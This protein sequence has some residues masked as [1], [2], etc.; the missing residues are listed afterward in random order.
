MS[1]FVFAGLPTTSTLTSSAAPAL[2][3]SPCGLK[4][5]PLAS[6][7]SARSMPFERGRAPTS[8]AT[9]TPSNA[10]FGSSWMSTPASS[11]NAQSNSSSA[12]PSAALTASG[13]SSRRRLIFVSS[14]SIWPE[15]MRNSSA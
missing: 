4:I 15:A 6:R 3:A 2:S 8:S 5:A 11:G 13:I 7:R 1:A 9:L 10:C 14:P 12:V